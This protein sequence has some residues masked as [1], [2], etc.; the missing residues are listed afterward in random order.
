M[1]NEE[2]QTLVLEKFANLEN[3]LGSLENRLDSLEGQ[4]NENT[5]FI[6][7]LLHRT[8][9]IAAQVNGLGLAVAK[10][11]GALANTATQ[12]DLSRLDSKFEVLNSRLFQQEAALHQLRA[13]K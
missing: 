4:L 6:K 7:S 8:E 3:R 13:V 1:T 5:G 10:I 2:F 11:E 9:E 12:E